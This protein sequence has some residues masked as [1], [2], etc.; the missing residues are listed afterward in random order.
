MRDAKGK[1][2][3]A[4]PNIL[5]IITDQQSHSM[6]S[7]A[8]NKYLSTPAMDSIAAAGVRFTRAYCANPVCQPSRFSL[9]TGVYPSAAGIGGDGKTTAGAAVPEY[10]SNNLLGEMLKQNGYDT[11]YGGKQGIPMMD[12]EYLGFRYFCADERG[13]L[14]NACADYIRSAS[15]PF[16][17]VASF[18]NPHDI[19]LMAINDFAA[20]ADNET[21][22]HIAKNMPVE[23]ASV[24]RAASL[25]P[26]DKCPRTGTPQEFLPP[27][28]F[29]HMPA[30]DEPEAIDFLINERG[31]RRLARERYTEEQWRLHRHAYARL[32]EEVDGQIQTVIDALKSSGKFENTVIILTS[33]HGD[34]DSAHKLEHKSVFYEECIRVP[35]LV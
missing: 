23:T 15:G 3:N 27:L 21:D 34:M 22:K 16:A 1:K 9:M 19:C 11:L 32:T 35:M 26:G 24:N 28:P 31:F 12:A 13:A 8:G 4:K 17:M 14:A 7:C 5:W 18:I 30:E 20:D 25:R 2:V 6:M 29:N 10:V 33:D